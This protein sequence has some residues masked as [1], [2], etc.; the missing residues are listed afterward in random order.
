MN[1]TFSLDQICQ[2]GN[3][4]C[5]LINRQ[6]K[7]DLMARFMEI[8]SLNPKIKQNQIAKDLSFSS[9]TLQ[10]YRKDINMFSPHRFPINNTNKKR[11][12]ISNANLDAKSTNEHDHKKPQMTSNDFGNPDTKTESKVK[13]ASNKR[14]KII[15]KSGSV[16][17]NIKFND[18]YL[19]EILHNTNL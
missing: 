17:Q 13:L 7:L 12:K 3:L 1:N 4:D 11:Q 16:Y 18:E 9:S 15:L 8:N 14:N 6:Y 2:T 10:R 5:N 19:N